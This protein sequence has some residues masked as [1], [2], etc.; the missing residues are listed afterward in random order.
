MEDA[1]DCVLRAAA[2]KVNHQKNRRRAKRRA[3]ASRYRCD[4]EVER[5]EV[6]RE[7]GLTRSGVVR[8]TGTPR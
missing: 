4:V 6:M 1:L 7:C 2:K 3:V 5:N 8:N